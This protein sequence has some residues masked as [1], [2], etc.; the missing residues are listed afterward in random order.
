MQLLIS[1]NIGERRGD[2][3][4]NQWGGRVAGEELLISQP[5]KEDLERGD[6][7]FQRLGTARHVAQLLHPGQ[8]GL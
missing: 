8:E 4:M 2:S 1:Q 5:P 6:P 3:M 7:A